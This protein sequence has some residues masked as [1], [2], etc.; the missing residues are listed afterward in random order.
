MLNFICFQN[1]GRRHVG[2]VV[3]VWDTLDD[4]FGGLYRMKLAI[5]SGIE[6]NLNVIA[7]V[8]RGYN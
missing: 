7:P 4:N 8:F 5:K 2:F 6:K 3:H 1:G